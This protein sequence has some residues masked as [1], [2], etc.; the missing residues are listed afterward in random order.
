[1]SL[2]WDTKELLDVD[3]YEEKHGKCDQERKVK[4]QKVSVQ[5]N[6]NIVVL[7]PSSAPKRGNTN[8][9]LM[10]LEVGFNRFCHT[11]DPY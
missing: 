3:D 1:M 4:K 5:Q 2:I 7:Q 10:S 8:L 11:A 9:N 6:F